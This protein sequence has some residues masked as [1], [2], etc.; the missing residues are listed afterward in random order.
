MSLK[1]LS[2]LILLKK[3]ITAY[4]SSL[5]GYMVIAVFLLT[6]GLF[7]WVIPDTEFNLIHNGVASLDTL[8]ILAPWVFLFL[9]PAVTMRMFAEEQRSGTIETLFTRPL[10]DLQIVLAKYGASIVLV[11][12]ALIP[13]IIYFASVY[14]L[15]SPV[16]NVDVAG[17]TG[18]YLGLLFLCSGFCSIGIFAS[19]VTQNQI[20]AFL[21]A[22]LLS[23]FFYNGFEALSSFDLPLTLRN[24]LSSMGISSHYSSLSR[25]VIDTRDVIY[26]FSLSAFFVFLTKFNLER[27]KW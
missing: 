27:R 5:M 21:I 7:M 16:G 25:G 18:S 2:V 22:L 14:W 12:I 13:S 24:I 23:F 19:S 3:E 4:L 26:F 8:F 9:I 1:F 20:I 10:S 15:A 6:M 11:L 17:I